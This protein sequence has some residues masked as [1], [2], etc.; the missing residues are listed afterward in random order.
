MLNAAKSAPCAVCGKPFQPHLMEMDHRD[1][2]TKSFCVSS[3][4][5]GHCSI[6]I[7]QHELAKCD[8]VCVVCHV[9]KHRGP[10]AVMSDSQE[11]KM[12][13]AVRGNGE[14]DKKTRELLDRLQ[15]DRKELLGHISKATTQRN[16]SA[17][18]AREVTE[19]MFASGVDM[20]NIGAVATDISDWR[21]RQ[22]TAAPGK[23]PAG[24]LIRR[25]RGA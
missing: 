5:T 4:V 15:A 23:T 20:G 22:D 7:F 10:R 8:P 24:K 13:K 12:A 3:A 17:E 6:A 11:D 14:A 1:P 2:S 18:V 9:T 16:T 21:N 25:R 19:A